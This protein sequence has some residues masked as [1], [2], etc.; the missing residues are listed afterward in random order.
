LELFSAILILLPRT[1][2][3]GVLLSVGIISGAVLM[4]LTQLGIEIN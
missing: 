4:H 2:W 1:I 3:A